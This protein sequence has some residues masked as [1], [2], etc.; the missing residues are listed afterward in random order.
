MENQ[1][2]YEMDYNK[3]AIKITE[4][5]E[6]MKSITRQDVN[7]LSR[8]YNLLNPSTRARV[9]GLDASIKMRHTTI[10]EDGD[11]QFDQDGYRVDDYYDC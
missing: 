3:K 10:V 2:E 4:S 7:I 11:G 8:I 9:R 5:A 6:R 1:S